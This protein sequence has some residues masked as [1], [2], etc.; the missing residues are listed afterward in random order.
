[1][2]FSTKQSYLPSSNVRAR[3]PPLGIPWDLI[4]VQ[5][6]QTKFLNENGVVQVADFLPRQT[7]NTSGRPLLHWLIRRVEVSS[8]HP[9]AFPAGDLASRSRSPI[10]VIRGVF[11]LRVEV[12]PAFNYA[13][14][15]HDAHVL[16]DRSVPGHLDNASP[17][18]K[19][20]F[21]SENLSLDFRYIPESVADG[22]PA[23]EVDIQLLDLTEKGH[24]G[25]SASA[26]LNLVEGQVVTFVLRSLSP[27]R[28]KRDLDSQTPDPERDEALQKVMPSPKIAEELGIDYKSLVSGASKFR[29]AD[30]PLLTVELLSELFTVSTAPGRHY[31][32]DATRHPDHEPIL[33]KLDSQVDLHWIVEGIRQQECFGS[34][35]AHL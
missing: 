8:L 7:S 30:D 21:V 6:L 2:N 5:I 18:K 22:V 14:D 13:R 20:L 32:Y 3:F 27:S 1:V 12:A 10:Q 24:L 4:S 34:K 26:D 16:T 31:F 28:V 35:V 23:P 29:A 17:H 15:K 25:L 9:C 19:A 11:P 33:G